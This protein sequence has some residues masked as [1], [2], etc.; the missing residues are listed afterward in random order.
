MFYGRI[1]IEN[2]A[3]LLLFEKKGMVQQ[4]IHNLKYK[5]HEEI[6]EFFG[7]WLGRDLS[8]S[9]DYSE[10]SAV[11]PV[12]LHKSRLKERGYN[13][14]ERFGK[15][16]ALELG[17]PYIN[18]VLVKKTASRTQTLQRR[19]ARWGTIDATFMIENPAKL[20]RAH[21]LLVDDLVTT[22]ATLE[23][24]AA[25][26]LTIPGTKVSIATIAFTH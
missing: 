23:A 5:G 15:A 9:G 11:V 4:L 2:A 22:G 6:G 17:V 10:I 24:C 18:N 14:V 12:P 8:G 16:I 3:A 26:I 21:V 19:F 7:K 1:K 13:Q 25:K 20:E